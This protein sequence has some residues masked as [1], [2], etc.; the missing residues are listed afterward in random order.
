L[1]VI[2]P[3]TIAMLWP[4]IWICDTPLYV[5]ETAVH[6]PFTHVGTLPSSV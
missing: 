4:S 3:G 5:C 2:W 1:T 6:T